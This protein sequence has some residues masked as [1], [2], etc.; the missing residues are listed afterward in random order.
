MDSTSSNGMPHVSVIIPTHDR[1]QMLRE[2]IE[3]ALAQTF[4]DFEIIIVLNG[5]TAETV[6]TARLLCEDASTRAVE[7][8][9][10]TLAAARNCGLAAAEGEWIAFLDD[11]DIWMAEK[12]EL[13]L[14]AARRSGADLVTCNFSQFNEHGTVAR[15]VLKP[16]PAGR[17]FAEALM[18]G[19][20][21][22]GGSQVIVKADRLRAA[23]GF[24]VDLH[25]CED[26]DM[27]RRLSWDGKFS[28][29]GQELVRMRRHGTNM[30]GNVQLILQAET[31]HFAKMLV[32]TPPR[33]HHMMPEAKQRFFRRTLHNLTEV[34]AIDTY[35]VL[36]YNMF[37]SAYRLLNKMTGGLS[38]KLYR[39]IR[40]A[41]ELALR[42]Q[43]A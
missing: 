27:W 34:G 42:K 6:E 23:G 3:S 37:F 13:Q 4:Q 40:K 39:G 5:A 10:G 18:L 20:Y 28:L 38:R 24:D 30:T 2:A 22:A 17:N 26:W 9:Y 33:L 14:D 19:N 41:A 43:G 12:L 36:L 29:V 21:V 25:A 32:D 7:L 16:L 15:A 8:A 35:S 1:P 11:D 31:Q